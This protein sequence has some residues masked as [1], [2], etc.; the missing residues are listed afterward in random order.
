MG[1]FVK[2]CITGKDNESYDIVRV[3]LAVFGV[4]LPLVLV[5][6]IVMDTVAY[7][8][9]RAF[10]IQAAFT[11]IMAYVT[12]AGAFLTGGGVALWLKKDTEPDGTT[13][14]ESGVETKK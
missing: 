13:I 3:V 1:R 2:D 7:I 12:G 5:W 4:M 11:G 10:D 9:N 6:G 14:E 8:Y